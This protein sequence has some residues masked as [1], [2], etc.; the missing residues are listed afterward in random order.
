MVPFSFALDVRYHRGR[1]LLV[2]RLLFWA[3]FMIVT[4]VSAWITA[5]RMREGS[6]RLSVER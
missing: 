3:V 4:T 2:K 1:G 5:H 6:N